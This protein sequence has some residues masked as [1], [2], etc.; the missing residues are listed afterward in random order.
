MVF[1]HF[2]IAERTDYVNSV[3]FFTGSAPALFYFAFG[4]T[5]HRFAKKSVLVRFRRIS[6]FLV[7]AV[8]H[9]L[10]FSGVVLAYEFFFFLWLSLLVMQ[11]VEMIPFD[12]LKA[13]VLMLVLL[14]MSWTC[15][16]SSFLSEV[17]RFSLINGN[18]PIIPWIG[19]VLAGYIF[20]AGVKAQYITLLLIGLFFLIDLKTGLEIIKY[21][22]S[23]TYFVLFAAF[24]VLIYYSGRT[25]KI[26]SQNKMVVFISK[27]LLLATILHYV[28]FIVI[29]V[30]NY[31]IKNHMGINFMEKY[32]DIAISILPLLCFLLLIALIIIANNAWGLL[33]V[34]FNKIVMFMS[35]NIITMA[36]FSLALYFFIVSIENTI[37]TRLCLLIC[38]TF[39]GMAMKEAS[40]E[41]AIDVDKL[42]TPF[43]H[44]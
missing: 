8:L 27:N 15:F 2:P 4:M 43:I 10:T 29:R 7:I 42:I 13:T 20:H 23:L 33:M 40:T 5:F 34:K 37:L 38:M 28:T 11:L 32:P 31:P 44:K 14:L 25:S 24:S 18:F 39:F 26:L 3:D 17:S 16:H 21:P 12:T 19:F 22:L 41:K 1:A 36:L 9:N 30:I 6:I 35:K